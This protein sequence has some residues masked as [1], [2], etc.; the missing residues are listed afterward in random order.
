MET[1]TGLKTTELWTTVAAVCGLLG[2][3]LPTVIAYVPQ[4]SIGYV[5]IGIVLAVATSVG[6]YAVSR[7]GVKAAALNASAAIKI[8]EAQ[9]PT[10]P[11]QP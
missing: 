9:G 8:A 10:R 3:V 1:K 7:G 2:A 6:A 11:P 5:I 4:D